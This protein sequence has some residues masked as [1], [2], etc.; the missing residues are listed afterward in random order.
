MG[1]AS[2]LTKALL[3]MDNSRFVEENRRLFYVAPEIDDKEIDDKR[4]RVNFWER[5]TVRPCLERGFIVCLF[6][7][8][9][10]LS[11]PPF[12]LIVLHLPGLEDY[13]NAFPLSLPIF[14]PELSR[15]GTS[16]SGL[17]PTSGTKT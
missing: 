14:R 5:Y 9:C 6:F 16:K 15:C 12:A 13:A 1:F 8:G 17:F 10:L 11:L 2:E 7:F 3:D 4:C